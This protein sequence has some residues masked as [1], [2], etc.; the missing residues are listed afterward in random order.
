MYWSVY[1]LAIEASQAQAHGGTTLNGWAILSIVV[2]AVFIA[3]VIERIV[4]VHQKQVEAGREDLIGKTALVKKSLTPK[5]FVLVEGELWSAKL[6]T[7]TAGPE[8]EVVITKVSD[9]ELM[10]TRKDKGGSKQ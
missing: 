6:D 5:G 3:F 10:V 2:L 1:I 8:D 9:L 7:G 4:R